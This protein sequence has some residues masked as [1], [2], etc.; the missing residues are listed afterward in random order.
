MLCADLPRIILVLSNYTVF[1]DNKYPFTWLSDGF[2]LWSES[3]GDIYFGDSCC[4]KRLTY[5]FYFLLILNE[6]ILNSWCNIHTRK[7]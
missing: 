5:L 1:T 7:R 3:E 6:S 4:R 2:I